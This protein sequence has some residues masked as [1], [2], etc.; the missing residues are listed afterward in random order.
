MYL[1]GN[2]VEIRPERVY[3]DEVEGLK[4]QVGG[5][6]DIAVHERDFFQA[7]RTGK[8]PNCDIDLATKVMVTIGL[9]EQSYRENKMARFDPVKMQ[10]IK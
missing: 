8:K 1:G 2:G 6:E 4:E 5:G 10:F 9:A 3:S 7:I